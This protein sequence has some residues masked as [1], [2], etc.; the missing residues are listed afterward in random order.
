MVA[1]K[2]VIGSFFKLRYNIYHTLLMEKSNCPRSIFKLKKIAQ[3]L[4]ILILNKLQENFMF[5]WISSL[6]SRKVESTNSFEPTIPNSPK[7]ASPET[8]SVNQDYEDCSQNKEPTWVMVWEMTKNG[9]G[10]V[11][12]QVGGDKPK[13]NL[14]ESGVY[15]SIHPNKIPSKGLTATIPLP[16]ELAETLTE[17]MRAETA[18]RNKVVFNDFDSTPESS[19]NNADDLLPPDQVIRIDNLDTS[20]MLKTIK[21]IQTDVNQGDVAYQLLPRLNLFGFL[22]DSSILV[23]QDPTDNQLYRKRRSQCQKS[24]IK[25]HN[26]ATLVACILNSG[27]SP[28]H[29]TS[30]PWGVTPNGLAEQVRRTVPE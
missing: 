15:I 22:R 2:K 19:M 17:D 25:T 16:A 5:E 14:E 1:K 24:D 13:M 4:L 18:G 7:I 6:F 11:A 20:E 21:K 27:G 3:F 9:P 26:C 28:V 23:A 8:A 30:M 10:H 12:V 29:E